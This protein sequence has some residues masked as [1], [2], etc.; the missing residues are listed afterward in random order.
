MTVD[1][2]SVLFLHLLVLFSSV[3]TSFQGKLFPT[4]R[5]EAHIVLPAHEFIKT[6]FPI[7]FVYP[8]YVINL[9]LTLSAWSGGWNPVVSKTWIWY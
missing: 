2:G 8:T 3:I 7:I 4:T 9:C 6:V 5:K 1:H